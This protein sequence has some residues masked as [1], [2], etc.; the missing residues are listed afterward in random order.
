MYLYVHIW[1]LSLVSGIGHKYTLGGG[2][3]VTQ[4]EV[5]TMKKSGLNSQSLRPQPSSAL[6]HP[7]HP[8]PQ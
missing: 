5:Q 8:K 2:G 4:T 7:P 3:K 6:P 1:D